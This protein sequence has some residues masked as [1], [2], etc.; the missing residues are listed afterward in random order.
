MRKQLWIATS[1]I[2]FICLLFSCHKDEIECLAC[3][4]CKDYVYTT[5]GHVI[6]NNISHSQEYTP[7]FNPNNSDEFVYVK[8]VGFIYSLVKYNIKLQKEDILLGNI[9]ITEEQ[10]KWGENGLIL[11]NDRNFQLFTIKSDGKDLKLIKSK[12]SFYYPE[13]KND[14][15]IVGH[16]RYEH[17]SAD[18]FASMNTITGKL[19]SIDGNYFSRAAYNNKGEYCYHNREYLKLESN[20]KTTILIDSTYGR[21]RIADCKWHPNDVDIYYSTNVTGLF[22]I[23]KNTKQITQIKSGCDTRRYREIS[24][25]SDGKKIIAH[26]VD[27]PQPKDDATPEEDAGIYLMDIDGKNEVK[28]FQ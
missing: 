26:R 11:F 7:C 23:N 2:I 14:S 4:P 22:K 6:G 13:W 24:I 1:I 9:Q 27:S 8:R 5:R 10:P 15:I 18:Y 3:E 25:S 28:L 19:D 16:F 20:K 17:T 12:G 21:E